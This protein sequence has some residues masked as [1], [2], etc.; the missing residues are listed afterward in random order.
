MHNKISLTMALLWGATV[1][2][3][4][5]GG[6]GQQPDD[7]PKN[8]PEMVAACDY[9]RGGGVG[10]TGG[11]GGQTYFVTTL[12]DDMED[13]QPVMGTLRYGVQLGEARTIL[14]QVA[15]TIHLKRPLE[16]T[17]GNL[18]I[19]GQSAPGDGICIADYPLLIKRA[20]NVIVRF[21]R[22]RMGAVGSAKDG[23]EYDA[24][25]VNDCKNV[26]LDHVSASWS[27][28][29]C[30]SCYGNT[31]FT[32]QYC[33]VTESLKRS[34]HAKG[35]H[36]YGGIWGG[37]NASFH[38]NLLAH[39]DSRNPRFDHDYVNATQKGPIDY[40]NN[41][42]YNWGG[43]SAYGGEGRSD[44]GDPRTINFVANYYKPGPATNSSR[45]DQLVNPTTKCSNCGGTVVPGLF[46]VANNYMS[47]S[48]TVTADNWKGV[49]PDDA[50]K[51]E[52]CKAP[53]RATFANA[54]VD[55]QS[56][57]EAYETVLT[58]GGCSLA[59]DVVDTRIVGEVRNGTATYTG[60]NGSTG[61]LIDEPEDVGGWPELNGTKA[62]DT[63]GDGIPD[64][65]EEAH[66]LNASSFKD[67]KAIT[68]VSGHTN[69]DVYLCD[70]V[71]H[72]Y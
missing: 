3:T 47:G 58:K 71:K 8:A 57:Q 12:S 5:C 56:A 50:G 11:D 67:G 26:V 27:V 48:E 17:K 41:V 44:K 61:G 38:H 1:A 53:A 23:D 30:V 18:T 40:I 70:I 24:I 7:Q 29:E 62:K 21:I 42:V 45:K 69:L 54:Y 63:D 64:A 66:G 13:G 39:H 33:F 20:N 59:R 6:P 10:T 28:D 68:L 49:R 65:W 36:G 43:N 14:F 52:Q 9:I 25:S 51:L 60:S 55:Q 16:I 2:F 46:W 22:V 19:A 72:L 15:G 4:S 31:D 37:T 35:N 34:V 32:M